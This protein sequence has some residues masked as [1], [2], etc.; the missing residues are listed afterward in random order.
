MR[1]LMVSHFY[2]CHM[3][4]IEKVAAHLAREMVA[5]GHSVTWAAA[6]EPGRTDSAGVAALPLACIN[7]TE[8]LSGLPM[9]IPGPRAL[10]A[11]WRAVGAADAV[12]VHDALY[13]TSITAMAMG[14]L[15]G[16]RRVIIQHIAAIPFASPVMRAI[17]ALANAVVTGP[18]LWAAGEVVFISDTVRR[19]LLGD[20][21]RRSYRLCFNGVDGAVFRADGPTAPALPGTPGKRL[22]FVGRYVEKK[23]L[24]ALCALARARPDLA[25]LMAGD[26]PIDPSRWGLPN[27]YVLGRQNAQSLAALYRSVDALVLPSV[28]EGYPLVVQEAMACGLP[29]V[30][31]APTHLAD[32]AAGRWLQGIAVDLADPQGTAQRLAHAVGALAVDHHE[33]AAMAA[34]AAQAYSWPGMAAALV[35]AATAT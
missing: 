26:G 27:V 33:R 11:L 34:Y 18:M 20:A 31:G 1:V 9:P 13:V 19:E 22:L 23:G 32:P 12:V 24:R 28:G 6:N 15:R 7:P 29:V 8:K 35:Q 17:M 30:C 10:L 3:G 25:L 2:E 4:G 14:W 21:P 16:K 5:A